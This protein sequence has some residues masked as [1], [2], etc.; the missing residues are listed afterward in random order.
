MGKPIKFRIK[1]SPI[2]I[3][4]WKEFCKNCKQER[5]KEILEIIRIKINNIERAR[6]AKSIR[7]NVGKSLIEELEELK[8][9][10][11]QNG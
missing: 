4:G 9:A 2:K 8:Q 10:L 6:R 1:Q 5:D 7:Y 11:K 3:V